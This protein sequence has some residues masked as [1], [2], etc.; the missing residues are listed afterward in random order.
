M[1]THLRVV[2]VLFLVFGGLL[3]AGG[4]VTGV[5]FGGLATFAGATE[6]IDDVGPWVLGLT[7][8]AF[9]I[10]L[11]AVAIP[12][13]AA[14]WGLL[15]EKRWARTLGIVLAAIALVNFW[16]GTAFGVYALWVLLNTRTEEIFGD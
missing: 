8:A 11:I 5:F 7:G 4:L 12:S 15:K 14:G 6:S 16:V 3:L 9:T 13:I 10:F 1:T 2:A